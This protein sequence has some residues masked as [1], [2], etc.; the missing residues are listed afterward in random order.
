MTELLERMVEKVKILPNPEQDA[1]ATLM[2]NELEDEQRWENAFTNSQDVLA[3]LAQEAMAEHL[4]GKTKE[5]DPDT[6]R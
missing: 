5:L 6:L 2:L 4:A 1:I 3:K